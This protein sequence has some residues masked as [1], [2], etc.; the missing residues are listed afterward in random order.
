MV[1]REMATSA[2]EERLAQ[3][4]AK[5]EEALFGA[6]ERIA[7]LEQE[8]VGLRD[9]NRRLREENAR[10]QQQLAAAQENSSTSSKPPSSD[11]VK[12]KKPPAK[13][14]K[15]RKKG[16]QPGH[17]QHLRSPF[18]AEAINHFEAHTLDCCPDC[19]G[20]LVCTP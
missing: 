15:K 8:D 1:L 16:G 9:E 17:D 13:G 6:T 4:V 7:T 3:R 11:I 10:L 20:T 12:P 14:G 18:P 5:L 2:Q 19:G